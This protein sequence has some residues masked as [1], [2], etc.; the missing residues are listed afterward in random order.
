[1]WSRLGAFIQ[2]AVETREPTQDL[3]QSFVQH[4]KGITQYYLETTDESRVA[5]NTDIPWRL[6]QLLDILVYEEREQGVRVDGVDKGAGG[7]TGAGDHA[8]PCMEYL[9]QHKILETLCT[10]AKAEYPPGMRQQVLLFYSRLLSQVQ[11]PLLHYLSVH[12]PVQEDCE[13]GTQCSG[14]E[15]EGAGGSPNRRPRQNLFKALLRLCIGQKGRLAVRAR[16]SLLGVLRT[17][18]QEGPAHLIAQSSLSQHV[19]ENLCELH[20][21][22]P[23]TTHPCNIT[24][25]EDTDWRTE[26]RTQELDAVQC[27]AVALQ[28]F[29]CWVEYC[30]CLVQE[31]HEVVAVEIVRSITEGYLHRTLQTEL[32]QV[33]ELSI[34]RSTAILTALLQRFTAP[35]LLHQLLVFVLGDERDPERR[36]DR[37][38]QLRPQLIQR[39]NHLSDEISLASLRLFEEILRVPEETAVHNLVTRNLETRSYLTGCQE[40]SRG[41][42]SEAWEGTEELEE[43][44]YFTDGFPDTGLRLTGRNPTQGAE[45]AG[46]EQSVKSFLSL[47]PEE[48]KSSNS[49]YDTYLQDALVQY[50]S[51]CQ[52]VSPW[53]WPDSPRPLG[54]VQ[55]RPEFY[56]GHFLEVLFDR[57]G[58]ILDQPY[59]VNLQV[60][61]LLARLSLFPH[62]HLQEYLLDPF[63]SLA[64]GVRTLFSVLIR[65][66]GDLAQRSLRVSHFQETLHLVRQQLLEDSPNEL[67]NHV[68]LC[69]GVVVLEEFCKE[70]AAAAFV[71]HHPLGH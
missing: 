21:G 16:E 59:E 12:R 60:T 54:T 65:V 49:G 44:P 45:L 50:R 3:L 24:A 20:Q 31:S 1:M 6:R 61:S 25:Q 37:G 71:T 36:N 33:S 46:R 26:I 28:K 51:C 57:L 38:C 17:A 29:L 4:W 8:G 64:P 30:N 62:P 5:R 47:V 34:L 35:P 18:Q 27:E 9:L 41:P 67:L 63:I 55:C 7:D 39:C 2:Q 10:L 58:G 23:L 52:Q 22:I 14:S 32:L 66:V 40:E 15:E 53:G 42:D 48:M 70:L 19:T 13:K 69:R 68:T 56:E 11:R 43:D